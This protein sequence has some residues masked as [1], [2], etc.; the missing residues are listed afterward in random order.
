MKIL[1]ITTTTDLGG[2]ENALLGLVRAVAKENQVKVISIKPLGSL[3]SLF[4]QTGAYVSSC[5]GAGGPGT[6]RALRREIENFAPNIVHAI[7]FRGM[8][9]A[10]LACRDNFFPLITTPHFDFSKKNFLFRRLDKILRRRDTY[11]IAESDSTYRYLL[12]EQG[13]P[14]EKLR[15]IFNTPEREK[16]FP[17]ASLRCQ[18]R[19]QQ[20]YTAEQT[21][22][23]SVA[24]LEKVKNPS[25]LLQAFES[26]YRRE[27]SARLIWVGEGSQRKKLEKL[28][29]KKNL[30][31]VVSL[32]GT[33]NNI[34]D[35]LNMADVFVLPSKEESLPL[36][37]L[38]ALQA[39]KPCI[40]STAGDMPLWVNQGENGFVVKTGNRTELSHAME[41]LAVQKDLREKMSEKSLK[42]S[43]EIKDM[44]VEYQRLYQQVLEES[45]H[46][47]TL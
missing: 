15:C 24:R 1:Y 22:F 9:C 47:K 44:V 45:F 43:K 33:Q 6:V 10:R 25:L 7:L 3:A 21:V 38:E 35:W 18:M 40:V 37:L 26:V 14:K 46:V 5:R 36:S 13:Y 12:A 17:D 19:T 28:I 11:T 27:K 23:L 8:E 34:N 32:A 2:A 42:K 30:Q 29:I 20:G 4:Q 31:Q 41:Q 39:G 16:F